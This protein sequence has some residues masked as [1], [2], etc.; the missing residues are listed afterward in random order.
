MLSYIKGE[1]VEKKEGSIILEC[2][3]IGY[4]VFVS[5]NTLD[6]LG[7]VGQLCSIYT[8]LHV[9]EDA[10]TLFGFA[11]TE[12]R[13]MFEMLNDVNGIGVKMAITIL[14]GMRIS[15]LL[16][17]IASEDLKA[18][19]RIKGLGKKTAERLVM[20]LKDRVNP[21]GIIKMPEEVENVDSSAVDEAV[22]ALLSL[23]LT[24]NESMMLARQ[25]ASNNKSAEE[26]VSAA[27]RSMGA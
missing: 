26:I 15:D 18:L 7:N 6:V 27:L 25:H 3:G 12:E 4:H 1:L 20:E 17:A 13:E 16:I 9:R 5:N 19:S 10:L 23:G 11:T 2:N 24:K 8:H 21:I 14:S 22:L